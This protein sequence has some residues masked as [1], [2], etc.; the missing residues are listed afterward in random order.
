IAREA[1]IN[2]ILDKSVRGTI[3]LDLNNVDA[4]EAMQVIAKV[5]KLQVRKVEAGGQRD[6]YVIA[7]PQIIAEGFDKANSET[8]SLRYADATKMAPLLTKG[9][10]K[11]TKVQIDS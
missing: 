1:K 8:V 9:L 5:N 4:L 3:P 10:G 2:I 7:D 6:T 11:T